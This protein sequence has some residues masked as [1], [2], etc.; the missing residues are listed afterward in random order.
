MKRF[1]LT[2]QRTF[3][4]RGCEAIVRS[5][6]GLLNARFGQVEV[7][8]PSADIHLDSAQWPEAAD[9][10]VKFVEAYTPRHAGY[11]VNLQRLPID[12][13]KQAGWPFPMPGWLKRQLAQVDAVL[14][15]GGDN[16]SLD[17]RIPSLF[18]GVDKLAMDMGKPL[19]LWGASVG[20][21]EREPAFVGSVTKHLAR[22]RFVAARESVSHDY[23]T[24]RLQL[25][26]V[27]RMA[28]PAFTLEKESID[29][30]PFWPSGN[31]GVL[32]INVSSLIERYKHEGQNLRDEV[33]AF[34]RYVVKEHE[35]G[36]LLVPHVNALHGKNPAGDAA[37]MES[38]LKQS[39]DLGSSVKM[40]PHHFNAAQIKY[41][42]S[43]LRFFIGAR[44]HATIAALS[45]QVP[46]VSIAYS[47]K[48][49][50]IN[51]D[52]FGN[53]DA[54]LHTKNVSDHALRERL[55]WLLSQEGALKATLA[56]RV[57]ALQD[58]VRKATRLVSDGL[59][60]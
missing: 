49:R 9:F 33:L 34:L 45:S 30:E 60:N 8:V 25:G 52:I 43:H 31:A 5:T 7:M 53:E 26:N 50:G 29:L 38:L 35:M 12:F 22:M 13:L 2:G 18:M 40:M 14:A 23:L 3:G 6:V 46:T 56:A 24:Q 1:Y 37:Y 19:V 47:V 54:V 27:I 17:Y 36:I 51:K 39:G 41:A 59:V 15:I 48:A 4:N 32:G 55:E 10:G 20:P 11:W 28:D 16:Y 44:T 57:P 42:I 21:F 58:T